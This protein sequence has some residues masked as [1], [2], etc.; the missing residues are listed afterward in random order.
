MLACMSEHME[1]IQSGGAPT[2]LEDL[3]AL[4]ARYMVA[5]RDEEDSGNP[6]FDQAIGTEAKSVFVAQAV[7]E[8][9][10]HRSAISEPKSKDV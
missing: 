1:G 7:S 9:L 6:D 10:I 4:I 8:L 5:D 3:A 2:L